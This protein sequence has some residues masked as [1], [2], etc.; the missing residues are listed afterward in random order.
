MR[1]YFF[2]IFLLLISLHSSAQDSAL[3]SELMKRIAAHQVN[4]NSFFVNGIFPS[5]I[6]NQLHFSERKKDNNIFFTALI[7]YTLRN[8]RS[9]HLIN[10]TP[11]DSIHV[12]ASTAYTYFKNKKGRTTYN[13]WRTD[14][15]YIFPYTNWIHKM[16][17]NTAL[18]DDMDDTVLSLLAQNADSARASAVH[19]EMQYYI[20]KNKE[21]AK[22]IN[23]NYRKYAAY[24]VWY[25]KDFPVVFDVCVL[26]NVL[27]FV[28]YYNLQWTAA[29]S[30]SLQIIIQSITSGDYIK[31]PVSIS[32]Y[33]GNTSIILYHLSR[34]MSNKPIPQLEVLKIALITT[35]VRQFAQTNNPLEK[36]ILCTA[37]MRWGYVPPA[38]KIPN[39]DAI[40]Q[41]DLPFFIGNIPSYFP[42]PIRKIFTRKGWGLFY[43][44]CPAYNDAL[45]VEYL[46]LRRY[47]I[48]N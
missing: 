17:K 46:A 45:F 27:H 11:Y 43:H 7:D 16:K 13:F 3:M 47:L 35:A 25:G 41:N 15:A 14:S 22:A 29:D 9:K 20:N 48:A 30:A 8:L 2:F 1:K 26:S 23:K 28:Q 5:Y 21:N 24:S 32:P 10:P 6:S 31:K 4:N 39:I 44:Y 42:L 18:P 37:I 34:L 40:E 19:K 12:Q 33:Y 38:F 36:A